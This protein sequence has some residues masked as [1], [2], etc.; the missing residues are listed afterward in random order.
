ME[1]V[2]TPPVA[3]DGGPVKDMEPESR[4]NEIVQSIQKPKKLVLP[5]TYLR[6]PHQKQIELYEMEDNLTI[7]TPLI[8]DM[9]SL[10]VDTKKPEQ[11]TVGD[12]VF[13]P[14][15]KVQKERTTKVRKQ[16]KQKEASSSSQALQPNDN[17]GNETKDKKE[18][19]QRKPTEYNIFVKETVVTLQE[20]H[21]HMT[22]KERFSLAIQ[23][24]NEKK[25]VKS[26]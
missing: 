9:I 16:N 25:T 18:V 1:T 10:V 20:S 23:M 19:K 3:L 14:E 15:P 17:T 26:E 12:N 2:S 21:K 7:D 24:W 5:K 8:N 13:E 22:S 4:I 11:N 6:G